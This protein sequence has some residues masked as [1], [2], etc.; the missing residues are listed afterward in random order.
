MAELVSRRTTG[1]D[2]AV[3]CWGGRVVQKEDEL[4]P[5]NPVAPIDLTKNLSC[6]L[7]GLFGNEDMSPSPEQVDLHEA[8]LKKYRKDYTFHRYDGAGHGFWYYHTERYRPVQAMDAWEK[9]FEFFEAL[10]Q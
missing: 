4:T 7:L 5:A 2:A 8:E 6:P 1:F 3:E 10:L 9:T